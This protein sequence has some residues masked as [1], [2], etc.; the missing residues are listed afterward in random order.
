[1]PDQMKHKLESR[2]Q[3]E[4]SITSDFQMIPPLWQKVLSTGCRPPHLLTSDPHGFAP[5]SC[6]ALLIVLM[7]PSPHPAAPQGSPLLSR[8]L[9]CLRS[10][11]SPL[12]AAARL[13][14][15]PTPWLSAQVFVIPLRPPPPPPPTP[16]F[17]SGRV[18]PL[19]AP[20][21]HYELIMPSM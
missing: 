21:E 17:R 2:F 15:V 3:E 9:P 6:D 5:R 13:Q 19:V 18:G 20:S 10:A 7:P 4:I 1:M 11:L 12:V 16:T 8:T 14:K